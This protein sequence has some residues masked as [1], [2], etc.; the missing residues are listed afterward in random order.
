M[1]KLIAGG[2]VSGDYYHSTSISQRNPLTL[3]LIFI[4]N[5][6]TK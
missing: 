2:N 4:G 3:E 6:G 5:L 1:T